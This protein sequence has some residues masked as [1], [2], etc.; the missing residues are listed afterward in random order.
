MVSGPMA[1]DTVE[2]LL[3]PYGGEVG[4]VKSYSKIGDL[5]AVELEEGTSVLIRGSNLAPGPGALWSW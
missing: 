1:G 3:G 4:T 5:F 2:V